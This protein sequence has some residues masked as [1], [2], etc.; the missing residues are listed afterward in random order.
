MVEKI[1]IGL[2]GQMKKEQIIDLSA[3]D[4]Y[5][6]ALLT[7]IESFL[8]ITTMLVLG[9]IC[10]QFVCTIC[11]LVFFLSL[12]KRTGGYHAKKF[13]QCY[14]ATVL[15]YFLVMKIAVPLSGNLIAMCILL[16]CSIIFIELIGT[17]NHPNVDMDIYEFGESQRA[18]RML[19][20]LEGSIILAL[21]IMGFDMLYVSY[22]SIAIILCAM[23]MCVAKIIKQEVKGE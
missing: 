2:V 19:V 11:F 4:N 22:M 23:L 3:G 5:E 10:K 13:W 8:T 14:L 17:V 7:M 20:L 1:V 12:R 15:T 16:I 6:Y 18:A 9:L 21:I